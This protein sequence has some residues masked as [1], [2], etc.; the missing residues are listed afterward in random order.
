MNAF[1]ISLFALSM[2]VSFAFAQDPLNASGEKKIT[3]A[4]EMKRGSSEMLQATIDCKDLNLL[5]FFVCTDRVFQRNVE[6]NTDSDG[7]RLGALL[8]RWTS[9]DA[10]TKNPGLNLKSFTSENGWRLVVAGQLDDF[11]KMRALQKK[12]GLDDDALL[13]GAGFANR[14][15]MKRLITEYDV[16]QSQPTSPT[17]TPPI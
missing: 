15:E 9:L 6:K 16:K 1:F 5:H 17:P 2:G 13:T 10:L 14:V 3:V 12:L 11:R 7:F 4:T 8:E